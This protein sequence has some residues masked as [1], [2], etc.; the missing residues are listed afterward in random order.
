MKGI[1]EYLL[2]KNKKI[3]S[4]SLDINMLFDDIIQFFKDINYEINEVNNWTSFNNT[5]IENKTVLFIKNSKTGYAHLQFIINNYL[6]NFEFEK[7]K[8]NTIKEQTNN[9]NGFVYTAVC[10]Y[11]DTMKNIIEKINNML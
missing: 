10:K 5:N 11:K 2:G 6:Y 1:L 4:K 3:I 8:L 7:F 9:G